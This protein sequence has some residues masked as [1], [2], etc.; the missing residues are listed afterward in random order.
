MSLDLS[1][2][3]VTSITELVE[4]CSFG[5]WMFNVVVHMV[6]KMVRN[7]QRKGLS[8]SV[9][10]SLRPLSEGWVND[11]MMSL[12]GPFW[13]KRNAN[14]RD[15]AAVRDSAFA[16]TFAAK[17]PLHPQMVS[18]ELSIFHGR[19]SPASSSRFWMHFSSQDIDHSLLPLMWNKATSSLIPP[20]AW[21]GPQGK[22]HKI[23]PALAFSDRKQFS[24]NEF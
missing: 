21:R 10:L 22:W 7:Q 8:W 4:V 23:F 16:R 3:L 13:V 9:A 11:H 14:F 19:A 12:E 17:F 6:Q 20:G 1:I 2:W 18:P 5:V 15:A 24:K